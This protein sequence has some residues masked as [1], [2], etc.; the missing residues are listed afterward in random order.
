ME[1]NKKKSKQPSGFKTPKHYFE[2]FEARLINTLDLHTNH[3]IKELPATGFKIPEAYFDDVE[4]K[5]LK[6]TEVKNQTKI[7]TLW[8][9][10]VARIAAILLIIITSYSILK[11]NNTN[12]NTKSNNFSSLNESDIEIYI[13]N[14]ILPYSEMRNLYITESE[15]DIAESN[16]QGINQ[17]VILRYLDH[18]L[19][20]IEL[21]DE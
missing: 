5:I 21:L 19:E 17:D 15:L 11:V 6:Q 2:N 12:Q 3:K 10:K 8:Y 16:L 9:Y 13:E 4:N 7:R 18:E 1:L 20:D 14:N